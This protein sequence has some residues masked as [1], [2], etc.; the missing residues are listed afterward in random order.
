VCFEDALDLDDGP[1]VRSEADVLAY[2]SFSDMYR[3]RAHSKNP[4]GRLNSEVKSLI[5][6][7]Y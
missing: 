2:M 7:Q 3:A 1:A 6:M 5:S 4:I